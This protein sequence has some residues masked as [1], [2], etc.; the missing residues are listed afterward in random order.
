MTT[1]IRFALAGAAL[2]T[3]GACNADKTTTNGTATT[4]VA[5]TPVAAPNNGDWSSVVSQTPEGGFMMGNPNAKVKLVEF[6]SLTCPH[7]A[8]FEE[9]GGQA[10]VDNYVKKGLVSFEFRNFVR[11][12]YDITAALIARCGGAT[13]FFGLTRAFYAS[14]KDWIGKIQTADPARLEALQSQGPQAQF[15]ALSEIAGFPAFAAMRGVPKAKTEAC[16]ADPAAATQLVQMNSDAVSNFNIQ[17]TPSFAINGET[18]ADTSTWKLL[19]PKIKA[20]LGS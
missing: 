13:S 8:E 20:S 12:P 17:G 11:D 4:G 19:E 6:G 10:L 16:L 1:S 15:K 18:I 5:A 9:Q 3:L 7:C 2:V 14:Q